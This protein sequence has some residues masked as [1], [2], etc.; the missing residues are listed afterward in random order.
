MG[1]KDNKA[2]LVRAQVSNVLGIKLAEVKF[3]ADGGMVVVGGE[4]GA[5]KSSLLDALRWALDGVKPKG[6]ELLH[7]GTDKGV[8]TLELAGEVVEVRR[9]VTEKGTTIKV[10]GADGVELKKP[11]AVLDALCG[12]F[13]IDPTAFLLMSDADQTKRVQEVMGVDFTDLDAEYKRL[14]DER[15]NANRRVRDAEG[16]LRNLPKPETGDPTEPVVLSDLIAQIDETKKTEDSMS[17]AVQYVIKLRQESAALKT[18]IESTEKHLAELKAK[19]ADVVERG[20]LAVA[21]TDENEEQFEKMKTDGITVSQLRAKLANAE[22]INSRVAVAKRRDEA[23]AKVRELAAAAEKV[24]KELAAVQVERSKRIEAEP[25]C[26]A[27]V[28]I[29]N[30]AVHYNN[31]PLSEASDGQRLRVAF[32]IAAAGNPDLKVLFLRHGALLDSKNRQVV[33]ELAR[34]RGYLVIMEVVGSSGIDV[35]IEEG[36]AR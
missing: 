29:Q 7:H 16:E 14:Y 32:E 27:G 15:T 24:D 36:V 23:S 9:G 20:K 11:Q 31:A 22:V 8:V 33:A 21:K 5:G 28:D 30:G 13:G 3:Q 6:K 17:L 10:Q 25:L 12:T 26:I 35:L 2:R 18:E 1:K 34:E 4:N 19:R